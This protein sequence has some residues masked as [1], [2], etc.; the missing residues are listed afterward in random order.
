MLGASSA[1][2]S[3]APSEVPT[4]PANLKHFENFLILKT[5]CNDLARLQ[6]RLLAVPREVNSC[7]ASRACP[8]L[9]LEVLPCADR[10]CC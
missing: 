5:Q 2:S 6:P 3:P 8:H 7:R 10:C 1:E 4:A 9:G